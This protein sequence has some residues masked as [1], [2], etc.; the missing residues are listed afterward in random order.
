MAILGKFRFSEGDATSIR[1]EAFTIYRSKCHRKGKSPKLQTRYFAGRDTRTT[2][3]PTVRMD[4]LKKAEKAALK[5]GLPDN[6]REKIG[7]VMSQMSGAVNA[8]PM[9]I[10]Y[11]LIPDDWFEA[12]PCNDVTIVLEVD[13]FQKEVNFRAHKKCKLRGETYEA[14]EE[15]GDYW[16]EYPFGL[17]VLRSADHNAK[18]CGDVADEQ[19]S[20]T[21]VL[22]FDSERDL[23]DAIDELVQYDAKTQG[24]LDEIRGL[25]SE[26]SA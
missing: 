18:C 2:L 10:D 7:A 14:G 19:P 26:A 22:E 23:R 3:Y 17:R 4:T 11:R 12:E 8:R 21:D 6:L 16:V 5:D 24:D 15:V 25:I 20:R 13:F 9:V 1:T